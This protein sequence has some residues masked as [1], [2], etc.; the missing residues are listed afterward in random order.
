MF[1]MF[2][3]SGDGYLS[4]DEFTEL[5]KAVE[6]A[7]MQDRALEMF[8]SAAD[9]GTE[10]FETLGISETL[11]ARVY[12]RWNSEDSLTW[13]YDPDVQVVHARMAL[14]DDLA[15]IYDEPEDEVEGLLL[16]KRLTDLLTAYKRKEENEKNYQARRSMH[17]ME[18]V[19]HI[20]SHEVVN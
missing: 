18:E 16:E 14:V 11:F 13:A 17:L 3:T 2:D 9:Y 1:L 4:C 7:T 5:V 10:E 20:Q 19:R 12:R 8:D 15:E 6:P